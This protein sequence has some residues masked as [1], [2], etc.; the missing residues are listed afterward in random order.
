MAAPTGLMDPLLSF[1][2]L[3]LWDKKVV[4]GVSKIALP[5]NTKAV[6]F[7]EGG[8]PQAVRKIPGQTNYGPITLERGL[9]IDVEFDQWANKVWYYENS[10]KL[11]EQ[12]SLKNFRKDITIQLCNQAG[13]VIK[14]YMA[15]SCWPSDY[16]SLPELD[17]SANTIALESLT[18]QKESVTIITAK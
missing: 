17:A 8:A 18:L 7:R 4:A 5:R 9:L 6:N 15:F 14:E 11:G 1:E 3:I 12:V 16:T 10:G 2:F 13:Q